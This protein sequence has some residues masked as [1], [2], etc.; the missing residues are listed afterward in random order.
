MFCF[1][2]CNLIFLIFQ[3]HS[4]FV[5]RGPETDTRLLSG[6]CLII[7]NSLSPEHAVVCEDIERSANI[8]C[9]FL[10]CQHYKV[11]VVSVY[12]FPSTNVSHCIKGLTD[13]FSRIFVHCKYVVLAEDLNIDLLC[14]LS[15][16]Q[17]CT[18]MLVDF[19]FVQHVQEPTRVSSF[20]YTIID[21]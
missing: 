2:G 3:F 1:T 8:T 15:P 9:C 13:L 19:Q 20:S 6:S 16:Q 21:Q 5:A 12:R 18:A 17:H 11:V 4:P 14:L 10:K 7:A